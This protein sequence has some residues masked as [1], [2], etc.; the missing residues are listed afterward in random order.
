[1]KKR[2]NRARQRGAAMVEGIV[3]MTTMLVFLG[4]N[5][6][7]AQVYGGK[8]D[9]ASSTRRDVLYY[10]SH[11]CEDNGVNGS[12]PDT[13]TQSTLSGVSGAAKNTENLNVPPPDGAR[14]GI[15]NNFEGTRAG[16]G[17]GGAVS[18]DWNTASGGKGPQ[19]VTG[20]A[21]VGENSI[22]VTKKSMSVNL[23]TNSWSAC[24]EKTYDNQWTAFFEFSWDFLKRGAGADVF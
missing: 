18:R 5:I 12:D 11:G 14:D 15:G 2:T 10:A 21:L 3:V 16:Q 13:Y 4:M 20:A 1:M 17:V 8:L 22:L 7:A 9:Q 23:G 24:N 6:W 19:P